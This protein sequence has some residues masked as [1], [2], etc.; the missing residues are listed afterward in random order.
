[1]K[2]GAYRLGGGIFT[3]FVLIIG[4]GIVAVPT[5]LFASALSKAREVESL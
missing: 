5:G 1:M 3:F 4:L 2:K